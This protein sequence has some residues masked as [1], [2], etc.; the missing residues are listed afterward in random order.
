M[1][2]R[3]TIIHSPNGFGKTAIF[4]LLNEI[5]TQGTTIL[6]TTSFDELHISFEDQGHLWI[7]R[8]RKKV[9]FPLSS[10][11]N[12]RE[13]KTAH[14]CLMFAYAHSEEETVSRLELT[15][16]DAG[17]ERAL[18]TETNLCLFSHRTLLEDLPRWNDS[19]WPAA[20]Q[21]KR[22]EAKKEQ[23]WFKEVRASVPIRFIETQRL[24][25]SAVV[26]EGQRGRAIQPAVTLYAQ[27]LSHMLLSRLADAT[28]LSQELD[29]TFP[30]RLIDL[31]DRQSDICAPDLRV[32]LAE[33]EAKWQGLIAV[34]LV[35][36]N[37]NETV[38]GANR[39]DASTRVAL[40]LSI[41]D[42]WQKLAIFDDIAPKIALFT[43]II[44]KRFLYKKISIS[45]REG[46][47]FTTPGGTQLP[48]EKLS[49]GEQHE[50]IL[51]YELLFKTSSGSLILIDEPENSL[52]VVW[53]EQFLQDVQ[54][55]TRL[56]NIDV[57]LATHSPDIIGGQRGL[58]VELE[59][60]EDKRIEPVPGLER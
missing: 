34:G 44:N 53:Q 31:V 7:T 22:G 42:T 51:F 37:P 21:E 56:A 13:A 27:E 25:N 9:Q 60:P 12:D 24:S 1:D 59:E 23:A 16:S 26:T 2:R 39:I 55:I 49:S 15:E 19:P 5:F 50:L 43:R 33:L 47:L 32:K 36:Q 10:E 52:H 3:V 46:F 20:E 41:K 58:V 18:A 54:D 29:R 48:L 11:E 30:R 45:R 40:S 28:I 6:R 38:L 4:K 17:D 14:Q 57:L 35:N 8:E